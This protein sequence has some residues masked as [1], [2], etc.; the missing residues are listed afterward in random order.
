MKNAIKA[1]GIAAAIGMGVQQGQ[2]AVVFSEIMYN[3][4]G[5]DG[6]NPVSEWIEIVNT[7]PA[8]VDVSGWQIDD[9]DGSNWAPFPAGTTL[10]PGQVAVIID[11]AFAS[12]ATF[13]TEWTVPAGALV[14][15]GAAGTLANTASP[16]NEI[17][18]LLDASS[19]LVDRANYEAGTA[20]WPAS[21][22]G[23]SIYA[24]DLTPAGNDLG[25]NWSLAQVGVDDARNPS[26]GTYNVADVGSPGQAP[27]PEPASLSLLGLG[28]L[29][30][31]ARRRRSASHSA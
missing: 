26:G 24:L 11:G 18:D 4:A 30:L 28:G 27:I 29:T 10:A 13:R 5:A 1:L 14:I 8:A 19:V 7:G 20:G 6:T 15:A 3:P 12:E 25:A 21:T 2:G 22:N 23:R 16:T 31:L 9:E 17:L